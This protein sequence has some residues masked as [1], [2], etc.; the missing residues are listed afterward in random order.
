MPNRGKIAAY[1]LPM[2][3]FIAL[4]ALNGLL[5]KIDNRFWLSS[6][7]YW[8]YPLQTV[9]CG[10]LVIWFRRQYQ[11]HRL[12]RIGLAIA[13]AVVVFLVWISPQTFFGFSPRVAGFDPDIFSG[14]ITLYWS[15][16]ILRFLRLVVVVPL[17]E[18]IFWRGFLLRYLIAE[19]FDRVAFGSFSWLSF[20][21]VT[22][23]F[24]FSHSK[25]DWAAAL[26]TG[27]LYNLVAYRAKSLSSCIL[28]HAVTNLLLGLWIMK[29]QQWGFW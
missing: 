14:Q 27:A 19:D 3:L 10:G 5:K 24:A 22:V 21:A 29:T 12:A 17:I 16:I 11:W 2:L 9:F 25:A 20:T 13:I 7:E 4:L 15:T 28:T 18:E 23:L 1:A 8:I 26:L 6:A